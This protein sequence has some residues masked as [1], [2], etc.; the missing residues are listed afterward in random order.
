V[1]PNVTL[2]DETPKDLQAP[3]GVVDTS[4]SRGHKFFIQSLFGVLSIS[5]EISIQG[6]HITNG[7]VDIKRCLGP[8]N[9]PGSSGPEKP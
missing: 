8:K 1:G 5:L 6:V 2:E 4:I 3:M 9:G 7:L